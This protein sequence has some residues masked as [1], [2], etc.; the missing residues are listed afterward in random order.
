MRTKCGN[1]NSNKMTLVINRKDTGPIFLFDSKTTAK[2]IDKKF[3]KETL[4]NFVDGWWVCNGVCQCHR[5]AGTVTIR[6]Q[7]LSN[8]KEILTAL[9]GKEKKEKVKKE[10]I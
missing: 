10:T 7:V 2:E 6:K 8:P 1:C 9:T 5:P 4:D 3:V